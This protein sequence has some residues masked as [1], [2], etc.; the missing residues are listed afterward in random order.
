MMNFINVWGMY[1]AN[2]TNIIIHCSSINFFKDGGI[3][4]KIEDKSMNNLTEKE[5]QRLADLLGRLLCVGTLDTDS[6]ELEF[7]AENVREML[8]LMEKGLGKDFVGEVALSAS[9]NGLIN[10]IKAGRGK[11]ALEVIEEQFEKDGD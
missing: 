11:Q 3:Q 9:A 5:T 10:E 6:T 8:G 4:M 2:D 1:E 7:T